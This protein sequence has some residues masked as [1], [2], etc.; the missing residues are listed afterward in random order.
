MEPDAYLDDVV[1]FDLPAVDFAERL[2]ERVGSERF[3]WCQV[4]DAGA[5]VGVLLT[6]DELDL[7]V[8][9]RGVQ[10]WAEQ[11]GLTAIRYQVDRRIYVLEA[12]K[13]VQQVA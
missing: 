13:V 10:T 4:T 8:L 3:A 2:V 12:R 11:A 7:A 1:L 6:P 9:L 5:F